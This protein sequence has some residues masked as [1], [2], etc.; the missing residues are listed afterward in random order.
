MRKFIAILTLTVIAAS[1]A[2]AQGARKYEMFQTD[3]I[4][5]TTEREY[6]SANPGQ[7]VLRSI[8][9]SATGA[10]GVTNKLVFYRPDIYALVNA[11]VN[12]ASN[13]VLETDSTT[14]STLSGYTL[15]TSDYLVF[16]DASTNASGWHLSS[17]DTIA[18]WTTNGTRT[19]TLGGGNVSAEEDQRAYVV[20]AENI[21]TT[22]LGAGTVTNTASDLQYQASSFEQRPLVIELL[23]GNSTSSYVNGV[24]EQWW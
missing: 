23:S 19:I 9:Y 20:K 14:L 16:Y 21:S 6:V 22:I 7:T 13:I 18:A 15:T 5:A 11:D 10:A 1:V 4:D 8:N 3:V 12:T 2:L 17:V 24:I